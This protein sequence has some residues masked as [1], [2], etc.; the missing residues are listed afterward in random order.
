MHFR[1]NY[2]II[3]SVFDVGIATCERKIMH[4]PLPLVARNINILGEYNE[5]ER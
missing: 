1:I 5:Q 3:N 4:I 2:Q